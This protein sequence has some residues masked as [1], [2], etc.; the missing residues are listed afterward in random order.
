MLRCIVLQNPNDGCF[1]HALVRKLANIPKI[2]EVNLLLES[3]EN[4]YASP[5]D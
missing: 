3:G 1:S 2:N 4:A 5:C